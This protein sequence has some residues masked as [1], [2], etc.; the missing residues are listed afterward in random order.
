MSKIKNSHLTSV[1]PRYAT[2]IFIKECTSLAKIDD[3]NVN[4]IV[5]DG[6]DV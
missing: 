3:Y 1:H 5:A 4:L 2:R 6:L